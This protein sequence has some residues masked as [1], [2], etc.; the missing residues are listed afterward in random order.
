MCQLEKVTCP[1][2]E[3]MLSKYKRWVSQVGLGR[4]CWKPLHVQMSTYLWFPYS[5]VLIIWYARSLNRKLFLVLTSPLCPLP[6]AQCRLYFCTDICTYICTNTNH[7]HSSFFAKNNRSLCSLVI[8]CNQI[9]VNLKSPALIFP[10][11]TINITLI[12]KAN[13]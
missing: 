2:E 13:A 3:S 7:K 5:H 6:L 8:P 9:R 11:A 12:W 4:R 10:Q 1:A